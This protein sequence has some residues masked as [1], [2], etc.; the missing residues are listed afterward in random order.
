MKH[1]SNN[2]ILISIACSSLWHFSE[3][4]TIEKLGLPW[5]MEIMT[6]FKNNAQVQRFGCTVLSCVHE[7]SSGMPSF[8]MAL[9]NCSEENQEV[10]EKLGLVDKVI[11]AM[12]THPDAPYVQYAGCLALSQYSCNGQS[13]RL[14]V[15]L[16]L[17][18][19]AKWKCD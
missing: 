17:L 4:T 19:R 7:F 16:I 2:E 11:E 10:A 12:A 13:T 1:F 15:V 5:I 6:K 14:I 9:A 3:D 8:A 18:I